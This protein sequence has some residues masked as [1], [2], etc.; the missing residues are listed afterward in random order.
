MAI[1][2]HLH[3]FSGSSHFFILDDVNCCSDGWLLVGHYKWESI[4]NKKFDLS[5]KF[6]KA[7]L[8]NFLPETG[9]PG[10]KLIPKMVVIPIGW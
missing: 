1:L 6:S 4:R 10:D 9:F 8:Q 5:F 3:F 2:T 7:T